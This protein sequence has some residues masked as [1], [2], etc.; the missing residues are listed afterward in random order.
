[1]QFLKVGERRSQIIQH[2]GPLGVAGD[3]DALPGGE[4]GKDL[5]AGFLELLFDGRISSSKLTPMEWFSGC[6]LSS[7]SLLCSSIIGFSKSS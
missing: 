4:V 7:S 2:I 5:A 3:L 1:M 6:S